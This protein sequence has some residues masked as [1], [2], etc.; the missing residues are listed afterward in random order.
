MAKSR[1]K[2]SKNKKG[3]PSWASTPFD[4]FLQDVERLNG[5]VDLS[6][7]GISMIRA[8]PKMVEAV[9]KATADASEDR[10][11]QLDNARKAAEL[12]EH[13]VDSGFPVLYAWAVVGLWAHLESVIRVFVAAW[14]KHRKTS[15][16]VEQI[17]RL[18][19]K[20]GEYQSIPSEQKHAF[21]VELLERE[22]GAGFKSGVTRF[23]KLLAPFGLSGGLP[24]TLKKT[25]YEFGQVRNV[26][27]HRAAK[28][29]RR[30]IQA[31]P[32]L[33]VRI[34]TDLHVS[35]DMFTRYYGAT[36]GYITLLICRVGE[37]YEV[38]MST[39]R[40]DVEDTMENKSSNKALEATA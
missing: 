22:L 30:F 16:Q 34:G 29:D 15:W 11:A 36:C 1:K 9:M 38:D 37:K 23:E 33:N 6:A 25:I 40:T 24:E 4:Q 14:L 10:K 2:K 3:L 18:P 20:L 27:A 7:K 21:V 28:V 35:A 26:I 17:Q 13:E 19:I 12:A 31:C 5:V 32:W 39:T 8:T